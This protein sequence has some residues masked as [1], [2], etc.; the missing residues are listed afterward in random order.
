MLVGSDD[1]V[2]YSAGEEEFE[3]DSVYVKTEVCCKMYLSTKSAQF[4]NQIISLFRNVSKT[5]FLKR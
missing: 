5:Q 4:F 1:L 2:E 3:E